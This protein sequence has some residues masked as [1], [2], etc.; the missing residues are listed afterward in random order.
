VG[1]GGARIFSHLG[2]FFMNKKIK[3]IKNIK[4]II[5][6]ENDKLFVNM[7]F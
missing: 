5:N 6:Y 3:L 7:S 1:S 2:H 4:K